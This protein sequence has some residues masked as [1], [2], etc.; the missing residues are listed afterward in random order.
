MHV[1]AQILSAFKAFFLS[2]HVC[3]FSHQVP[4][5][6]TPFDLLQFFCLHLPFVLGFCFTL[7]T[8]DL[9][10]RRVTPAKIAKW[11][12][13][14]R[15]VSQLS[16]EQQKWFTYQN[17]QN[18]TRK[19]MKTTAKFSDWSMHPWDGANCQPSFGKSACPSEGIAPVV[20]SN[21]SKFC[22]T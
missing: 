11:W 20:Q 17:F 4:V 19:A 9:L 2:G 8:R 5:S 15:F 21:A 14:F 18:L 16:V 3:P 6:C 12:C 10:L 1:N 22:H 7:I 13:M